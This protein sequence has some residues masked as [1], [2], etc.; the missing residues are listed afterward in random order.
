MIQVTERTYLH[1]D[2]ILMTTSS[3]R[4]FHLAPLLK[5]WKGK[6][7]LRSWHSLYVDYTLHSLY[8]YNYFYNMYMYMCVCLCMCMHVLVTVCMSVCVCER[9]CACVYLCVCVYVYICVCVSRYVCPGMCV[10]AYICVWSQLLTIRPF[11]TSQGAVLGLRI[12]WNCNLD[13]DYNKCKPRYSA[14]RL[15][16]RNAA[17]SPG[18]NFRCSNIQPSLFPHVHL[19]QVCQHLDRWKW[20]SA[21]A[22]DK[23]IR[24]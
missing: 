17:V 3:A 23:G 18:F 24:N 2:L 12:E 13:L 10:C 21:Q 7:H 11:Y 19:Q 6:Q 9:V 14:R 16:D 22:A 15:D 4:Y 20:N 5:C 8:L 1:V